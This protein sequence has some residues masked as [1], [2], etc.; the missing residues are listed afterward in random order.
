MAAGHYTGDDSLKQHVS[1]ETYSLLHS[2]LQAKIGVGSLFDTYKPWLAA[3]GFIGLELQTM[4]YDA[5]NGIDKHFFDRAVKDGKS[6]ESLETPESQLELLSGLSDADSEALLAESLKE[7]AKFKSLFGELMEAWKSGDT[8]AIESIILDSFRDYPAIHKKFLLDRNHAWAPK[9]EKLA[10]EGGK[11]I[12]IIGAGHLV[13]KESVVEL[14]Q[15]SGYTVE[16][17]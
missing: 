12:V 3:V 6:I 17:R 1:K 9:I 7:M 11:A 10:K 8:K 16:Q 4:G 13:G 5:T 2:N 15:K 14:L